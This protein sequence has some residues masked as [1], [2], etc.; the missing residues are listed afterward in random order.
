MHSAQGCGAK[1]VGLRNL[2][3]GLAGAKVLIFSIYDIREVTGLPVTLQLNKFE[4][5]DCKQ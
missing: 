3:P 4:N 1:K 2:T 5:R